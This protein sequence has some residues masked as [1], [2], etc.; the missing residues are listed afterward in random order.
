MRRAMFLDRDGVLIRNHVRNGRP[1]AITAG[2]PAEIIEGV[3]EACVE[4]KRRGFL[5]V[6]VTNQPDVAAGT[7]PQR[8]VEETNAALAERL[9]LDDV[10]VCFH[11]NAA[12]CGCRKPKPGMLLA[13][14]VKLNIDVSESFMVGDRWRDIEAAKRAGCRSILIDYGYT[15][16]KSMPPDHTAPS[17]L[18]SVDWI[19]AQP[20][21]KSAN[22]VG[23][24]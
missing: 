5:L 19:A 6:M 18:G 20:T 15:D 9:G 14:A 12:N 17:L 10:E 11:D 2:E 16:K 23:S 13:A 24:L 22:S 7:T 8:F 21:M 3:E 1:Y 4:L